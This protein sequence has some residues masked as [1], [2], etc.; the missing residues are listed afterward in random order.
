MAYPLSD[1]ATHTRSSVDVV[2]DVMTK[3]VTCAGT[4]PANAFAILDGSPAPN[5][6]IAETL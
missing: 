4:S 1:G 6:F 5:E 2:A 3:P